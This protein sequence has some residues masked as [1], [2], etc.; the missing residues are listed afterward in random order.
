MAARAPALLIYNPTSGTARGKRLAL[1]Q[2]VAAILRRHGYEL[3]VEATTHRASAAEQ[4]QTAIADGAQVV[5]ACGGDGT[6]H[7]CLQA[8]VGTSAALAPIPMGSANALCRELGIPM[9][10]LRAA[11]A[12]RSRVKRDVRIGRCE[13]SLGT[14]CFLLMVGAGPDG[15]LMYRMLT[16]RRGVLG[17]WAYALHALRLLFRGKFAPFRVRYRAVDDA[18]QDSTLR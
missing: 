12:Y 3:R 2:E 15:A 5:F 13:S 16:T 18:W 8:V 14:R 11:A 17:R 9:D 10:S 1:V 4:V 6:I 7:D